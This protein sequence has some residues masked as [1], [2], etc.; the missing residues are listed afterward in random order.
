MVRAGWHCGGAQTFEGRREEV[1]NRAI[2]EVNVLS[3]YL[4]AQIEELEHH[5]ET[6]HV[7][8]LQVR[9][10][11]ADAFPVWRASWDMCLSCG[12]RL[13]AAG[14]PACA[15][16]Y[17]RARVLARDGPT[18]AR[19]LAEHEPT[20]GGVQE[21]HGCRRGEACTAVPRS[22][23]RTA[24][25]NA[26]PRRRGVQTAAAEIDSK[27]RQVERLQAKCASIKVKIAANDR[28]MSTLCGRRRAAAV[29]RACVRG[30]FTLPGVGWGRSNGG[31][32]KERGAMIKHVSRIK[33]RLQIRRANQV[34]V[35][36]RRTC[37]HTSR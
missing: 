35:R 10:R 6:A 32:E 26:R 11:C 24:A 34:R 36:P 5:F 16:A 3:A 18:R 20:N 1:R 4:D 9:A 25:A 33:R 28:E 17:G 15:R 29:S 12:A 21:A 23:R 31:V 19:A 14:D 22:R 30:P 27:M 8:Y 2:E 7:S 37:R 13:L